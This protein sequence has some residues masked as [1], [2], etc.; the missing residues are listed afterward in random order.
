MEEGVTGR[1]G[2]VLGLRRPLL[3]AQALGAPETLGSR[4]M[5]EEELPARAVAVRGDP[6]GDFVARAVALPEEVLLD[7]LVF[8]EVRDAVTVDV[9]QRLGR[10]ATAANPR[11]TTCFSRERPAPAKRWPRRACAV[12]ATANTVL[13]FNPAI[14][15]DLSCSKHG[16]VDKKPKMYRNT[17]YMDPMTM[18][19]AYKC[20]V[21]RGGGKW[22]F[23]FEERCYK[24]RYCTFFFFLD[25]RKKRKKEGIGI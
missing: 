5:E 24:N 6:E 14:S 19:P 12:E 17:K 23:V 21:C 20:Y 9:G 2:G 7:V 15:E 16:L 10:T 8:E 4:E 11:A 22:I 1:E 25:K 3:V 18:I 13:W